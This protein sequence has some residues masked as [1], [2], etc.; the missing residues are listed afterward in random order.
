LQRP[1][2]HASLIQ[3]GLGLS[4]YPDRCTLELERRTL[5]GET[6]AD[7]RAELTAIAGA[8]READPSCQLDVDLYLWRDA[9]E[10]AAEHQL[11]RR[12]REV[13]GEVLG[14]VPAIVGSGAWLDSAIIGRTI[15]TAIV[16]PRGSVP[17]SAVEWVDFGTVAACCRILEAMARAFCGESRRAE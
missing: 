7:V 3:G 17:H 4:T 5:P 12:L 6:E 8:L 2:I 14:R 16:G 11:V 9:Y 1:S 10:I 13:A 15:P